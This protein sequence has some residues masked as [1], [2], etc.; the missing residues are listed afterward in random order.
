[1][2]IVRRRRIIISALLATMA[3]AIVAA[4]PALTQA[5]VKPLRIS[6]VHT[7]D[8]YPP[9]AAYTEFRVTAPRHWTIRRP[10]RCKAIGF[11]DGVRRRGWGT[12]RSSRWIHARFARG[13]TVGNRPLTIRC[14]RLRHRYWT[15]ERVHEWV[16]RSKERR[17]TDTSR[18]A[19]TGGCTIES[20]FGNLRLDCF[21]GRGYALAKY[22]FG[23]PGDARDVHHSDRGSEE[24]CDFGGK[25]SK[26]WNTTASGNLAFVVR[27]NGYRGYTQRRARV[28]YETRVTR[29]ER[30]RHSE[31]ARGVG[32]L[33]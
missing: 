2:G 22:T 13:V 32:K 6:N 16:G 27:V 14:P 25:I 33:R 30:R 7:V 20:L 10:S 9:A 15:T 5:R 4:V 8:T 21:G 19:R 28:S 18:R 17:G 31:F 11:E 23:L 1:L 29:R 3:L 12:G 24:C 26:S